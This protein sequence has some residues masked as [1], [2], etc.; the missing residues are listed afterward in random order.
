[1]WITVLTTYPVPLQEDVT[2]I[3]ERV[4]PGTL[5]PIGESR[6]K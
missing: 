1:M 2:S 4:I 6:F 5:E 3:S